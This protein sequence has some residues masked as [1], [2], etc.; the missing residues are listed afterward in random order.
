MV[1]YTLHLGETNRQKSRW[2]VRI[3]ADE[4]AL[5]FRLLFRRFCSLDN[6]LMMIIHW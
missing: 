1:Y 6:Y 3:Y 5:S 4:K 2:K